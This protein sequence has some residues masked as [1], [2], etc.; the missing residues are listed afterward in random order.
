MSR[1]VNPYRSARSSAMAMT[2]ASGVLAVALS[3]GAHPPLPGTPVTPSEPITAPADAPERGELFPHVFVDLELGFVEVAGIVPIVTD[4]PEGDPPPEVLLELVVTGFAGGRDHES[5]VSTRARA[6]HVHA[7]LLLLGLDPGKP[8][9]WDESYDKSAERWISTPTPPEGPAVSVEFRWADPE[10]GDERTAEPRE[11]IRNVRT[12]E[13]F[14][15][16]A[17]RFAGSL[18]VVRQGRERYDADFTGTIIGLCQF[19]SEV[20]GFE[21]PFHHDQAYET[22]IWFARNE[23]VP[24]FGTDVRVR[25][26]PI[27]GNDEEVGGMPA[28]NGGAGGDGADRGGLRDN[29]SVSD[30]DVNAGRSARGYSPAGVVLAAHTWSGVWGMSSGGLLGWSWTGRCRVYSEAPDSSRP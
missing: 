18:F 4:P 1:A 22:P 27:E 7:A 24:P 12:N 21:R 17:W 9:T 29:A 26:V 23:A 19:G 11:W 20:L 8:G 15:E 2:V 28:E 6:S 14:P 25:L 10:T 5:L 3:G 13:A 16:G 30:P